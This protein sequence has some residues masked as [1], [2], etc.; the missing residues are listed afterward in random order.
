MIELVN[1]QKKDKRKQIE[2][3]AGVS[4]IKAWSLLSLEFDVMDTYKK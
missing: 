1:S 2:S 3:S 4:K